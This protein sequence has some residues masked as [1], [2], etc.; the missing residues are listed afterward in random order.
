M[1]KILVINPNATES[2][3]ERIL[4]EAKKLETDRLSVDSVTSFRGP[5]AIVSSADEITAAYHVL[6][7]LKEREGTYDAAVIACAS[8][9]GLTAAREIIKA[10]VTGIFESAAYVCNMHGGRF[11]VI[12]S[13]DW[14]DIPCFTETAKRYSMDGHLASVKYIGTGVCGVDGSCIPLLDEKIEEAKNKDGASAVLLGCAA[15]AGMGDMLTKKH[16]IY[17]SDGICEAVAMAK[18]LVEIGQV[19]TYAGC[20]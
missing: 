19:R 10:P 1:I 4:M 5:K 11:S 16:G 13:C 18:M 15:F 20:L 7:E 12:G 9:P 17:V 8:D 3:T 2:I 6:E 14:Q